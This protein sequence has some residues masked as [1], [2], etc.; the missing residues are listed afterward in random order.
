MFQKKWDSWEYLLNPNKMYLVIEV[1]PEQND[2]FILTD[3]EGNQLIFPTRE[4][5]EEAVRENRNRV[6]FEL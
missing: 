6:L 5:A 1:M 3:K 2:A 4:D